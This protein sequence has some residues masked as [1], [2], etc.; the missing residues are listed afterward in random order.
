MISTLL[1]LLPPV[2]LSDTFLSK[3]AQSLAHAVLFAVLGYVVLRTGRVGRARAFTLLVAFGALTELLQHFTGRQASFGD[4]YHDLLGASLAMV[5]HTLVTQRRRSL[6]LAAAAIALAALAPFLWS[7]AAYTHRAQRFPVLFRFTTPID[8]YFLERSGTLA[9]NVIPVLC[10]D[11]TDRALQVPI[12]T[13]PFSGVL[14]HEPVRDWNG[15]QSLALRFTL[16]GMNRIVLT[17][18][19]H[20]EYHDWTYADRFNREYGIVPGVP[21]LIVIPLADIERG[22]ANGRRL[23][24]ERIAGLALFRAAAGQA[25]RLCL[26][27][28]ILQ[29]HHP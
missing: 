23:D 15:M 1:V 5:M 24:L 16:Q 27:S 17:V 18:R 21:Q 14:L 28:V 20:D 8:T 11:N 3:A 2:E 26:S 7:L 29:P 19:V 9:R 10:A 25:A 13:N 22:P 12:G 6:A 4:L